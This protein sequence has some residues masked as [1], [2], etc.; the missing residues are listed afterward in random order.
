MHRRPRRQPAGV[1]L[2]ARVLRVLAPRGR[3][4]PGA[5]TAAHGRRGDAADR[6]RAARAAGRAARANVARTPGRRAMRSGLEHL[7]A[8]LDDQ[9]ASNPVLVASAIARAALA[10]ARS[11]SGSHVRSRPGARRAHR[12]NSMELIDGARCAEDVGNGDITTDAIVPADLRADRRHGGARARRGRAASRLRIDGVRS[13]RSGRCEWSAVRRRRPDYRSAPR[14]WPRSTGR[15]RAILTGERTGTQPAAAA[16]GHRDHH[17]RLCRRGRGHRRRD[18]G[19][20][21]DRAR[22]CDARQATPSRCGGG[23]NHRFGLSDAMLI[24]D[25]HI[26]VAGGV[27]AAVGR[28]RSKT[29]RRARRSRGRHARS[30]RRRH[31]PPAPTAVLLDNMPPPT[32]REAVAQTAGRA[33]LEASGGITLDTIA[34]RRRDRR[35][36]DLDRRPHP[37]G[38]A[39][40]TSRWRYTMPHA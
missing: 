20:A 28:A 23:T 12:F 38:V 13:A 10:P 33:R 5:P 37:F 14:S 18:P 26:A 17:P 4:R 21:Q 29:T 34:A 6:P 16:V 27:D 35:R 39:H 3:A 19:H 24:K 32:L 31:S 15:A 2:T 30:A 1:Q 36:R 8:W 7:L 40:S 9:P 11:A 22:A 25:N